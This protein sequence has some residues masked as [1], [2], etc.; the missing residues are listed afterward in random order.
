MIRKTN[1]KKNLGIEIEIRAT[2]KN[3]R[4]NKKKEGEFL[5]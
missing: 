4:I 1:V 3:R 2:I 5:S